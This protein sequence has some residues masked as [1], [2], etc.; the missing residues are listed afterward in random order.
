MV[1]LLNSNRLHYGFSS[2]KKECIFIEVVIHPVLPHQNIPGGKTHIMK[3]DF[4]P[5]TND[6]IVIKP[7][8]KAERLETFDEIL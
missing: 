8:I 2:M 4:L 5:K 6:F 3:R 1:Y 7:D